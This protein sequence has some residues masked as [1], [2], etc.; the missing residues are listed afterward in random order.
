MAGSVGASL[1]LQLGLLVSGVLT[2]RLLGVEGRGYLVLLMLVPL[3]LAPLA[4]LGL[5]LAVVFEVSRMPLAAKA[6]ARTV[7]RP[8]LAQMVVLVLLHAGALAVLLAQAPDEARRAGAVSLA[9]GPA[10]LGQ[11][12]A[13][14]VLQGQGNFRAFNV[15]RLLPFLLN[16]LFVAAVFIVGFDDLALLVLVWTVTYG[17]AAAATA[18]WA[19]RGL[20]H[21]DETRAAP[22]LRKML[23][24]GS[25]ALL[26]SASPVETFRI[27]QAVVGLFLSPAA[28]G[29]YAA[30]LAF[31]N[32]PRLV[33][34]G[35]GAV[36]F[37][38]V[39]ARTDP[40]AARRAMWRFAGVTLAASSVLVLGLEAVAGWLVTTFFGT[41]FEDAVPI[42]QILL[43]G[44]PF[45]AARR[46][47][48][49]ASR[50]T[51]LAGV[52]SAGELASWVVLVPAVAVG[53][54]VAGV[55]GVAFGLTVSATLSALLL[56]GG[57]FLAQRREVLPE[58]AENGATPAASVGV[59]TSPPAR[60][61]GPA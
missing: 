21:Q 20:R 52:G 17:A 41:S 48:T 44:A 29:L 47:L 39:A 32:L 26:G 22:P 58:G 35:V 43:V 28:L 15:L 4:T 45:V 23:R 46:V 49:D 42:M 60:E 16:S 61:P 56:A 33:A 13:L 51:G 2:A 1:L 54:S 24:F 57:V 9:V 10:I 5:P 36:A 37:P 19:R 40:T 50:G 14:A 3:A 34:L 25:K 31:T 30:G 8:A 11:H 7:A 18:V 53:A 12:Y 55:T 27:D 6:I 38:D 59:A